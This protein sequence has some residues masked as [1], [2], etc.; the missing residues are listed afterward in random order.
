ME[1]TTGIFWR[2]SGR[3]LV[4]LDNTEPFMIACLNLGGVLFVR[5]FAQRDDRDFPSE[6][7]TGHPVM[8]TPRGTVHLLALPP[9]D[10]VPPR[11]L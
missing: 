7:G 5:C 10:V 1:G 3:I 2:S 6:C 4:L 9:I 11:M 8:S